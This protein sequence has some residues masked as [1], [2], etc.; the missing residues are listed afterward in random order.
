MIKK[1]FGKKLSRE[2][3]SRNALFISLV[4]SLVEHGK[5]TTTKAKAK[6]IIGLVDKLVVLAKKDSLSSK[7]QVLKKLRGN[8]V[9]AHKLWTEIAKTFEKRKSGFTRIVPL[10]QRKGDMAQMVRLE[11][12]DTVVKSVVEIDKKKIKEKEDRKV[13]KSNTGIKIGKTGKKGKNSK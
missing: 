1:I 2:K 7:R 5:I 10:S 3:T 11:W 9:I 8:K 13:S 12:V 6:A 4:V